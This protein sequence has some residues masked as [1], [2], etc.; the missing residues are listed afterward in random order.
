[1]D[2]TIRDKVLYCSELFEQVPAEESEIQDAYK[3]FQ[4]WYTNYT[5]GRAGTP[6]LDE[7]LRDAPDTRGTILGILNDL[8][9]ALGYG[10]L[11]P[12]RGWD[13]YA[14]PTSSHGYWLVPWKGRQLSST[15][16]GLEAL[17]LT[18]T[19]RKGQQA[20]PGRQQFIKTK[21]GAGQFGRQGVN[22]RGY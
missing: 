11:T 9:E 4:A 10:K 8:G 19:H 20:K 18:D 15:L 21:R 3:R 16:P 1:M 14:C 13:T 2:P 17:K 6:S 5:A 7:C 22:A 12:F